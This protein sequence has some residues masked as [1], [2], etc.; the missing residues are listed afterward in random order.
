V[1]K[2]VNVR[3]PDSMAEKLAAFGRANGLTRSDAVRTLLR[4]A[5]DD[6]DVHDAAAAEGFR[7]GRRESL[8]VTS[9]ALAGAAAEFGFPAD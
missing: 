4:M 1:A 6:L 8:K 9:R 5:L 3:V 7:A 2:P